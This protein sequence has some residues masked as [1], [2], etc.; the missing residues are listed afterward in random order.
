MS[1]Y[2]ID[3]LIIRWRREEL[4]V[5]QVVGQILQLL[6]EHERRLIAAGRPAAGDSLASSGTP[7]PPLTHR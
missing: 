4:T 5:E 6:K 7:E 1:H 2:S 3:D